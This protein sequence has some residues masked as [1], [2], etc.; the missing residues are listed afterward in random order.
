MLIIYS[1]TFQI[2][3]ATQL[4]TATDTMKEGDFFLSSYWAEVLEAIFLT[5]F[6]PD[7]VEATDFFWNKGLM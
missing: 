3:L 4:R 1:S 2:H 7:T 5:F 6:S